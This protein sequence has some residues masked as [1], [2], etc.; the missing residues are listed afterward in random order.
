MST[1]PQVPDLPL[2]VQRVAGFSLYDLTGVDSRPSC[3]LVADL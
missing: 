1:K 2:P 3:Y